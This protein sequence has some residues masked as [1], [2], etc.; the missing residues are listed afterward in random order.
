MI[1]VIHKRK[2]A[3]V[4]LTTWLVWNGLTLQP[5]QALHPACPRT[6]PL[7][8][9]LLPHDL[10]VQ[11]CT[12]GQEGTGEDFLLTNQFMICFE[13]CVP[14]SLGKCSAVVW[15]ERKEPEQLCIKKDSPNF[16]FRSCMCCTFFSDFVAPKVVKILS[17]REQ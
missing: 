5:E 14:A 7:L 11:L 6:S 9:I 16:D 3:F 8:R 15:R 17:D 12:C 13:P 2:D 10:S 1:C 4:R